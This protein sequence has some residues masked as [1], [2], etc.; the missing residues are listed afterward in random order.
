M[1]QKEELNP[2]QLLLIQ[3]IVDNPLFNGMCDAVHSEIAH[4]V[5]TADDLKMQELRAE[6]RVFTKL[7]GRLTEYANR[8]RVG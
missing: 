3:G 2:A 1:R 6:L 7:V 5:L 4:E 8:V